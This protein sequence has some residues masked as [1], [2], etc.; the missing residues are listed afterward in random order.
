[1][2]PR[3]PRQRTRTGAT[4]ARRRCDAASECA[5]QCEVTRATT[6]ARASTSTP[7]RHFTRVTTHVGAVAMLLV[8]VVALCVVPQP[9]DGRL[10]RGSLDTTARISVVAKFCFDTSTRAAAE[11]ATTR[12]WY[13]NDTA[14][15]SL[16]I[17]YRAVGGDTSQAWVRCRAVPAHGCA[18]TWWLLRAAAHTCLHTR[19]TR[20][21]G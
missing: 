4:C 17:A 8:A 18:V 7:H 11:L 13:L 2:G 10:V 19:P 14:V 6:K 5:P 9:A 12:K 3:A 21:D 16:V 1:M 15:A 20:S